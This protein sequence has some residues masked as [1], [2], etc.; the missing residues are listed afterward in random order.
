MEK[1]E[2]INAGFP[3]SAMAL[4]I[5]VKLGGPTS[6]FGKIKNKPFLEMEKTI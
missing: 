1:H 5:N 2:S 6:Y 4:S 3:I